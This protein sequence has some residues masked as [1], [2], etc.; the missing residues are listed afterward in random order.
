M[1]ELAIVT[2]AGRQGPFRAHGI[3]ILRE[4]KLFHKINLKAKHFFHHLEES[5]KE[6]GKGNSLSYA[7]S[8][9]MI[10]NKQ[11]GLEGGV[12]GLCTCYCFSPSP[13]LWTHRCPDCPMHPVPWV[14]QWVAFQ[15][16]FLSLVRIQMQ[17]VISIFA[18]LQ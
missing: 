7:I 11:G 13:Q 3:S 2:V 4:E 16:C 10:G 5:K 17:E 1:T 15:T 14:R 18:E 12:T 6:L 8:G 9:K